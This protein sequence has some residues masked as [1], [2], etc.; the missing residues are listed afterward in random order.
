MSDL[1]D[2]RPWIWV[3]V[4]LLGVG[5]ALGTEGGP[6]GLL[7]LAV[8]WA[9]HPERSAKMPVFR[10]WAAGSPRHEHIWSVTSPMRCVLCRRHLLPWRRRRRLGMR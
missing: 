2:P 4:T 6:L 9:S 8:V 7:T 10:H 5:T 1:Q 3:A